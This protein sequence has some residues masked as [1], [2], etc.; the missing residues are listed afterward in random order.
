MQ[1]ANQFVLMLIK[2]VALILSLVIHEYMHGLIAYFQGD[3]TARRAGRL[4]LNPIPHLDPIGSIALPLMSI[5]SNLPIFGWA[6]PVPFNPYN[7][8][9]KKWG[10]T[11]VA[12]GGPIANFGGATLTLLLLQFVLSYYHLTTDNLL[13]IFLLQFAVINIVLGTFNLIPIP[14]LDG[15]KLLAA[16]LDGPQ[17]R[18]TLHWLE[19]KGPM[20]LM[21]IILADWFLNLN[22]LGTVF[23]GAVDLFLHWFGFA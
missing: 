1:D 22:I 2:F 10:P 6:K 20:L 11:F 23:G 8:R 4:T 17:H 3:D 15:S 9:N 5:V 21:G 16:V 14:P 7:L 18:N 12:L 13:V 19:T